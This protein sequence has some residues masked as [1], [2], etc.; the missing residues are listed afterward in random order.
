MVIHTVKWVR[1]H[2]VFAILLRE[3][4]YYT[5]ALVHFQDGMVKTVKRTL[6]NAKLEISVVTVTVPTPKEVLVVPVLRLCMV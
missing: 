2:F 1:K 6:T 3:M 4:M 5:D